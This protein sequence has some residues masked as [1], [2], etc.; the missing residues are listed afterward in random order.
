MV[1][2]T[3]NGC[4]PIRFWIG[5]WK[6]YYLKRIVQA[7]KQCKRWANKKQLDKFQYLNTKDEYPIKL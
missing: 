6:V 4:S 2:A 3:V 5:L 7:C 1:I